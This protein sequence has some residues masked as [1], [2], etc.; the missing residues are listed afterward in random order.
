MLA[1]LTF[2]CNQN[3]LSHVFAQQTT[4][5]RVTFVSITLLVPEHMF[6]NIVP[7]HGYQ[8]KSDSHI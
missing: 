4:S 2:T 6:T 1:H 8:L 3:E 5:Q 7:G